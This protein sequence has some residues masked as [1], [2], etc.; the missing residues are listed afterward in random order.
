MLKLP[1][2]C[3]LSRA[4]PS[5]L[6]CIKQRLNFRQILTSHIHIHV[7]VNVEGGNIRSFPAF[8]FPFSLSVYIVNYNAYSQLGCLRKPVRCWLEICKKLA[9]FLPPVYCVYPKDAL[10]VFS[11]ICISKQLRQHTLP[12]TVLQKGVEV[13]ALQAQGV[14]VSYDV[15]SDLTKT[16]E[17]TTQFWAGDASEIECRLPDSGIVCCGSF[18]NRSECP[19][20][21]RV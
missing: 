15:V 14:K 18:A 21:C 10:K 7:H 16:E 2:T 12:D 13:E 9:L 6:S 5:G 8:H 4:C 20:L 19:A 17:T 3:Q 1:L 11:S